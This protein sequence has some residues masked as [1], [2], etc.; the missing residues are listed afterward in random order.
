VPPGTDVFGS[1]SMPIR[2]ALRAHATLR[3]LANRTGGKP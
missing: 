1:P 3:K 2:E